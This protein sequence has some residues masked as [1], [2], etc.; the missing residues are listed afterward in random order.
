MIFHLFFPTL[1]PKCMRTTLIYIFGNTWF[2]ITSTHLIRWHSQ[3]ASAFPHLLWSF[4][5]PVLYR[6]APLKLLHKT[7]TQTHTINS[8]SKDR[9]NR[10]KKRHLTL[11]ARE[12]VKMESLS[13]FFSESD[14]ESSTA[15]L[16]SD[17]D[18]HLL[19]PSQPPLYQIL[20]SIFFPACLNWWFY[21]D[22]PV[23]TL[24]WKHFYIPCVWLISVKYEFKQQ[25]CTP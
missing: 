23:Q 1:T 3:N 21:E 19:N 13:L 24:L 4:P 15:S 5:L 10:R 22:I 14:K 17:S 20:H 18:K 16:Q 2:C 11:L 9:K 6:P 12:S 8:R 7:S 25:G